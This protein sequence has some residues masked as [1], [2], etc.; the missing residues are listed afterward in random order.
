MLGK[1]WQGKNYPV[2]RVRSHFTFVFPDCNSDNPEGFCFINLSFCWLS[3]F[4]KCVTFSAA[5]SDLNS[6]PATTWNSTV[7]ILLLAGC[8]TKDSLIVSDYAVEAEGEV[9]VMVQVFGKSLG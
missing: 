5:F 4:V 3:E 7:A 2:S 1:V 8:K 6:Q 9:V